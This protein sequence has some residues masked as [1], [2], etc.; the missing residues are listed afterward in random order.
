MFT[1]WRQYFAAW[2]KSTCRVMG[3]RDTWSPELPPVPGAIVRQE[4]SAGA[5]ARQSLPAGAARE[6]NASRA[7]RMQRAEGHDLLE[8]SLEATSGIEPEYTVLQ[9][10]A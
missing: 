7:A 4:A 3:F 5:A 6:A 1:A 10:V 9:T 2:H 8:G